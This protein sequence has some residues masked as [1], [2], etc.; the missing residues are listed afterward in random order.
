MKKNRFNFTLIILFILLIFSF[1][2]TLCWGTYEISPLNV[3]KTLLGNGTKLQ[4]TAV[5][6]IRLPRLSLIHI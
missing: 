5:L 1:G 6:T 4:N 3:I 2:V